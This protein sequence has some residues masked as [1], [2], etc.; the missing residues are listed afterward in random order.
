MKD[1]ASSLRAWVTAGLIDEDQ[2][3]AILSHEAE[4]SDERRVPLI[5]EVLGYLGGSLA[6]I[7]AFILAGE[8]WP[9][10]ESWARLLLVGAGTAAFL[11][12][13]WFI[14]D[15]E[16]DAILR[17]SSFSWAL[18]TVGVAFFFGLLAERRLRCQR[19]N[20][21]AGCLSRRPGCRVRPVPPVTPQPSADSSWVGR[22]WPPRCRCWP[23]STNHRKSSSAWPSGPS[24]SP[25]CC[26]PGASTCNRDHGLC[27][28][29]V[30]CS[31]RSAGDALR[32]Q[33]LADAA[34][35]GNGRRLADRQ[36]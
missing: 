18:G 8:F 23:I 34:G 26:S 9:D 32:R 27:A 13:G 1:L 28:R 31:A 20:D 11:A 30:R 14:K 10:L 15:T 35:S 6:L 36:R 25:G 24:G 7:A 5:A 16:N 29:V 4:P 21:C 17:L 33:R 2:A 3:K 22:R 19:G 12:A